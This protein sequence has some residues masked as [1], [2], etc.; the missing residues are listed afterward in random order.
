[1]RLL[2]LTFF[3]MG[4]ISIV[5]CRMDFDTQYSQGN[6]EFSKDTIY[7]DTVFSNI[8]SSTYRLKVY[9]RT[10]KAITIPSIRLG[11]GNL[12]NYRL[13]VDGLP[14]KSFENIDI[15]AKDSIFVFIETTINYNEVTE[16]LYIDDL[17]FDSGINEQTV[18]L[19]T[20]VQDAVFLYPNKNN[21]IIETLVLD[22]EQT[23]LKGRY[24]LDSELTFTN[25]RPYVIYGYMAV[26][27]A[28]NSPKTLTLQP[29]AKVHFHA[30]SGLI[31]NPNSSLKMLGTRNIE[32]QPETEIIIEGDRL[33]P[34]Y[35][36]V[37]G[38]WGLIWLR[39]GSLNHQINYTTI[40]NGS[41]G[42]L[43]DGYTNVNTPV[44]QIQNS[45]FYNHSQFGVFGRQTNIKGTNLVFNN[46]GFTS[47]AGTQ[48]GVYDFTHCTFANYWNGGIR[49]FPCV[50]INN[51]YTENNTNFIAF[52]LIKASFVNCIIYGNNNIELKLEKVDN[53]IFNY[54]FS[55]NLIR[56]NDLNNQYSTKPQYNFL[57]T[58]HYLNNILNQ[59]PHF[60]TEFV[61]QNK[62]Y[63]GQNSAGKG[64]ALLSGTSLA[65]IDITGK[66]R[67]N[68]ADIG[69]YEFIIFE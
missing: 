66:I 36:D 68:P 42:L 52:D 47:F 30:N 9:N 17:L 62:M 33:E 60:K 7:L 20:L 63:I 55:N 48:G 53:G 58:T 11:K 5:S 40:K 61:N 13:N 39:N 28:Q 2:F 65:P 32:G 3:S 21:G 45:Q 8:G 57:D 50:L 15:L 4:L 38:Q 10:N 29:G 14:G 59:N 44:I 41:I 49:S 34:L 35:E 51:F 6:L 1:M 37:P 54:S 27:N 56:F 43:I 24:L 67:A 12:S 22:G 23:D 18:K 16:P 26:G 69:A 19:V 31:V 25:V 64:H 46:S